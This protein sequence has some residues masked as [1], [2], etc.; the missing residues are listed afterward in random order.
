M[1]ILIW[2]ILKNQKLSFMNILETLNLK[3]AENQSQ[4]TEPSNLSNQNGNFWISIFAMMAIIDFTKNIRG[5]KI[6]K[7]PHCGKERRKIRILQVLS[8]IREYFRTI[9]LASLMMRIQFTEIERSLLW[10]S[11]KY[12]KSNFSDDKW[13][14]EFLLKLRIM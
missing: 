2:V 10:D 12:L 6:P 3:K 9:F 4:N 11:S 8:E 13:I 14:C 7:S 1:E 5:K